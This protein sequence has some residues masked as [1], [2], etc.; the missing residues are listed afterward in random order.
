VPSF[1]DA[2][3]E[4]SKLRL[5]L[6]G[7]AGGGKSLTSLLLGL[8][9]AGGDPQKLGVIDSE[10]GSAAKYADKLPG[11]FKHLIMERYSSADYCDA[12]TQALGLSLPATVVDS[13]SHAWEG[14]GG[15]LDK[16]ATLTEANKG[17]S[18]TGWNKV[19]P[20]EK[21]L[22]NTVL[23]A[24]THLIVTMRSRNSWEQGV[25]ETGKKYRRIV[26]LEP[27]QRKGSEYEF[28]VVAFME[29]VDDAEGAVKLTIEKTRYDLLPRGK[30]WTFS[31]SHPEHFEEFKEA[32]LASVNAGEPPKEATKAEIKLLTE[33]LTAEGF[34]EK[35]I[36]DVLDG[37]RAK[38]NGVLPQRFVHQQTEKAIRRAERKAA[39]TTPE[40][41]AS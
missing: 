2:V 28:D 13:F 30:S 39:E 12:I 5:A 40:P 32:V 3:K 26:G 11:P 31:K 7:P 15:I 22:W 21:K 18:Q 25:D 35:R 34:E 27:I 37:E 24:Q 10:H 9:L 6:Y 19:K 14:E 4:Q 8:A 23:S 38:W 16:Q 1:Q 33:L 29:P 36:K 41:A 20:E 17:D